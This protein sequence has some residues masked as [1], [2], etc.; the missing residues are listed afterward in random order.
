MFKKKAQNNKKIDLSKEAEQ[1][2]ADQQNRQAQESKQ[3]LPQFPIPQQEQPEYIS[4]GI[5]TLSVRGKAKQN[6]F[7]L[8]GMEKSDYTQPNKLNISSNQHQQNVKEKEIE[9]CFSEIRQL[10]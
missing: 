4:K 1:I 2:V 6:I 7:S 5:K 10:R 8:E 9:D 3:Q